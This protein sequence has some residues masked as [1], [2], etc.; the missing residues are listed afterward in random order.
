MLMVLNASTL[1]IAKERFEA[2]IHVLLDVAVKESQARLI[3]G[4]IDDHSPVVRYDDRVLKN[5][6]R[7]LAVD[8]GQLP[9]VAVQ[10]HGMSV[11]GAV[12]HHQAVAS[13][14]FEY[15]FA[16]MGVRLA[17]DQ[18]QVELTRSARNLFE[19]QFDCL[20]RRG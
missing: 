7:L 2:V 1:R 17:V 8:L 10:V 5:A 20:L 13:A 15:E 9:E 11:V 14:P 19:G 12:A 18:P 6:D 16:F 4:E 3:S